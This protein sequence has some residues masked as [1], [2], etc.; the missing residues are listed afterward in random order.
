[1]EKKKNDCPVCG[2]ELDDLHFTPVSFPGIDKE[3]CCNCDRN[4]GLMFTN[5]KEKPGDGGFTVPDYSDR[6]EQITGR[7]YLENRLIF[8]LDVL[9]QRKS[10]RNP[11]KAEIEE[12]KAE[13]EKITLAIK[14]GNR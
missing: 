12:I 1:M 4:I 7:S 10:E 11:S 9:R 6:I 14:E 13:I 2:M 5:F 8:Y 3:I